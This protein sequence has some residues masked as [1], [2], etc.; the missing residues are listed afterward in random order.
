MQNLGITSEPLRPQAPFDIT[1]SMSSSESYLRSQDYITQMKAVNSTFS[2]DE[3]RVHGHVMKELSVE[4]QIML[5]SKSA[6][7]VTSS[8]GGAVTAT[9]LPRGATLIIYYIGNGSIEK[10]KKTFKPAR[11]DWDLFNHMSY[12]RVHWL[13]VKD[14]NSPK[15]VATFLQLIRNELHVISH[16]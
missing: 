11:L 16:L 6:I 5:A 3:V 4:E 9:F 10:N 14:M 15:G 12:I 7:F 1:F 13:P 2:S 8:G